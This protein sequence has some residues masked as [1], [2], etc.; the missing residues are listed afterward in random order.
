MEV[1]ARIPPAFVLPRI[2]A[3]YGT[4]NMLIALTGDSGAGKGGASAV[5]EDAL[6]IDEPLGPDGKPVDTFMRPDR[7]PLGS[8]EGL[9][10]NYGYWSQQRWWRYPHHI[11]VNSYLL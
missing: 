5:A 7:V 9:P 3:G 2:V 8:G 11:Y 6:L 1:I 10:K 4:L